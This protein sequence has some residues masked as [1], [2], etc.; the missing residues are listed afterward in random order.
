MATILFLGFNTD[1]WDALNTKQLHNTMKK[2]EK[3][4]KKI[5]SSSQEV[6]ILWNQYI[7]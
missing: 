3:E 1:N 2:R 4:E 7:L 6:K 5:N